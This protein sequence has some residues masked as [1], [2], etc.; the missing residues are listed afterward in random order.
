MQRPARSVVPTAL[1]PSTTTPP[2]TLSS[3]VPC[4]AAPRL[5]ASSTSAVRLALAFALR[6]SSLSAIVILAVC[7]LKALLLIPTCCRGRH[8]RRRRESSSIGRSSSE[9]WASYLCASFLLTDNFGEH[10]TEEG[11]DWSC[12]RPRR[13]CS[14]SSG[15]SSRL[16]RLPRTDATPSPSTRSLKPRGSFASRSSASTKRSWRQSD[17]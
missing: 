2:T 15:A 13:Y 9:S 14:T 11:S 10:R 5:S 8:T 7:R 1:L 3:P 16:S 12:S 4:L 6:L 17:T